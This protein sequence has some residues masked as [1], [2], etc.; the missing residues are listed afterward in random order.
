MASN[1]FHVHHEFR[2]GKAQ[3][4]WETAQAAMSPGGGW[5]EALAKNL[6]AGFTTTRSVLLALKAL[7]SASG[8]SAKESQRRSFKI[9]SMD[10]ME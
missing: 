6:E 3:Q 1:F 5:G 8:K 7:P 9:S 2:A 10:P 4:W